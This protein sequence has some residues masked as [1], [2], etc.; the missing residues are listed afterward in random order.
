MEIEESEFIRGSKNVFLIK[1][2]L[3]SYY[4]QRLL[5]EVGERCSFVLLSMSG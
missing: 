3:V 4:A 1:V 5:Y 2:T